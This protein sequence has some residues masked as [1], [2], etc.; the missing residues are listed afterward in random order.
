MA[1]SGCDAHRKVQKRSRK[2]GGC[3]A[4]D[5][6]RSGF[7]APAAPAAFLTNR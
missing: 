6:R 2:P 5:R 4:A 1:S 3:P 7:A